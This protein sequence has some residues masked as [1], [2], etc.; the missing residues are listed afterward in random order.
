MARIGLEFA[1]DP[2]DRD[3]YAEL[4]TIAA[5]MFAALAGGPPDA[6]PQLYR[7]DEGYV[8]PKVDVRAVVGGAGAQGG[9][10]LVRERS[11]GLWTLPGGW[12]DV[13]ESAAD[14]VVREVRE[15]SGYD[16]RA[17][18]LVGV[19]EE[20]RWAPPAPVTVYKVLVRCELVGGSAAHSLETD[21]V[22]F[23]PAD[24]VPA[25]SPRRTPPGL[26]A[27]GFAHLLDPSLPAE[28]D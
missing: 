21:G 12:A 20:S 9:V 7:P 16:V 6:L 10:L 17:A 15:E 13:G 4:V 3:R 19:Y 28:V 25:L 26:L 11:D 22:A 18:G 8:T 27:R 24:R 2:Y 5:G 14:G 23:F 1:T